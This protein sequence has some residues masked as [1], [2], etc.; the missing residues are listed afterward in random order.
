MPTMAMVPTSEPTFSLSL[1]LTQV[2]NQRLEFFGDALLEVVLSTHI[3]LQLPHYREGEMTNMRR[4]MSTGRFLSHLG[5][6]I[7]AGETERERWVLVVI[8]MP[9]SGLRV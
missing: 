8:L 7:G 9:Y 6:E 4:A 3:Y 5:R 1:S 2:N